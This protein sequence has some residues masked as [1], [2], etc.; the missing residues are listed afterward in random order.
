MTQ[1]RFPAPTTCAGPTTPKPTLSQGGVLCREL[2]TVLAVCAM[3]AS[4]RLVEIATLSDSV[5]NIVQLRSEEQMLGVDASGI[6]AAMADDGVLWNRAEGVDVG[7]AVSVPPYSSS[8]ILIHERA[9]PSGLL[10]AEP[11]PTAV[12]FLDLLPETLPSWSASV[13]APV[14]EVALVQHDRKSNCAFVRVPVV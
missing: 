4:L 9:V 7:E 11:Q 5:T 1:T 14:G 6:I 8:P 10:G 2:V 3:S 13:D 12:R